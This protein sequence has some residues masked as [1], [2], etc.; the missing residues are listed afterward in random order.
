MEKEKID[1]N[2]SFK[3]TKELLENLKKELSQWLLKESP[4]GIYVI[5]RNRFEYVNACLAQ[6]VEFTPQ[7]I[8]SQNVDD[9]LKQ[10]H[11]EDREML[12]QRREARR[13]GHKLSPVFRLR[14]FTKTGRLV[15]L[16]FNTF[17]VP[18]GRVAG[19]V[20]EVSGE[21][22]IQE[23]LK[24]KE[25]LNDILLNNLR[26][27]VVIVE[28]E[29]IKFANRAA[30][31]IFG[32]SL[33]EILGARF[34]DFLPEDQVK[35]V[36]ALHRKG[37]KE[38]SLLSHYE[39]EVRHKSGKKL[40]V[41]VDVS[42]IDYQG[43]PATLSVIYDLS[44]RKEIEEKL[45]KTLQ[46][47]RKAFGAVIEVL[48]K[49]IELKDPYTGGHERRVAD[50]AR[51][52]ATEMGLPSGMIEGLRIAAQI[53]DIGKIIVPAEILSKPGKLNDSEW[54]LVKNHVQIGYDLLKDIDFPWPVADIIY[55]HHERLD[56]SG[57]PRGLKG[58]EIRLEARILTVADV[59]EAMSSHRPYREAFTQAE[60]LEEIERKKGILYDEKVVE[61]CL[62]L[63][64]EKGYTWPKT[65]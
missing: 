22:R 26:A 7:E 40:W 50:L 5:S 53:H 58:E 4:Y 16:E 34:S 51:A 57:Y 52:I 39:L 32:Y 61:A 19:A 27:A 31:E 20:R 25:E 36:I 42:L 62:R 63:F 48:H 10:V 64:R 14:I 59:V 24:K 11:P 15:H 29:I 30:S 56:G 3:L 38:K 37:I 47:L 6:M 1:K 28:G 43:F 8:L 44:W 33:E 9:L 17:P 21:V 55:Q 45:S 49:L 13:L 60:A 18:E 23:E 65:G 35:K 2:L 54:A 41:G 46:Q 12:L